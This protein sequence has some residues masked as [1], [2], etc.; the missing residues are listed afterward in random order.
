MALT[1]LAT[2]ADVTSRTEAARLL[3]AAE[4]N[5][6]I[7]ELCRLLV[8]G[9][10]TWSSMTKIIKSLDMPG[11]SIRIVIANYMASCL[12]G[13]TSDKQADRLCRILYPFSKPF[14]SSDK[15]APLLLAFGDLL[16][17]S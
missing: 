17:E 2:V 3:E 5:A 15:L 4:E 12:L 11:E 1:M 10:L 13:A 16:L 7:I 8:S 9:K 14:A 6:E